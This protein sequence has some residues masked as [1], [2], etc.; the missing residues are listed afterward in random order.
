MR[1]CR[2]DAQHQFLEGKNAEYTGCLVSHKKG[3]LG[4]IY[5]PDLS[6][7]RSRNI[8]IFAK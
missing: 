7:A 2:Y 4:N 1:E 5:H 3:T 8:S 6:I